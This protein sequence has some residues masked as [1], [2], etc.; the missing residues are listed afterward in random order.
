[1]PN[2]NKLRGN[3]AEI[4]VAQILTEI[5]NA[6]FLR[7]PTSGAIIGASNKHKTANMTA[8]QIKSF[9][10][11]IIPPDGMNVIIEVKSRQEF[12]FHQLLTGKCAELDNWLSQVRHD[13]GLLPWLLCFKIK[14]KSWFIV[15]SITMKNNMKYGAL[16]DNCM[17]T[18]MYNFLKNNK[19]NILAIITANPVNSEK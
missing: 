8:G 5:F 9:S 11:D 1:M 6:P 2:P 15:T 13:A 16:Y 10:G 17:I 12:N 18:E 4:E 14:R 7:T 3:R 19:D